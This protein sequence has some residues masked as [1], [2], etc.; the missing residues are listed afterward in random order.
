MSNK[1]LFIERRDQGDFA[2]RR[3]NSQRASLVADTQ[4]E[5][6]AK[7]QKLEPDAKVLVE[8]VR[9]T[10]VGKPDKMAQTLAMWRPNEHN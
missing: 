10:S 3:A 7:A 5:A 8:R 1:D 2:V 6:I 4:A 9:R